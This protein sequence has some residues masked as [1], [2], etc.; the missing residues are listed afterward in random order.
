MGK[1]ICKHGRRRSGCKDCGGSGLCEHGRQRS[2]CKECCGGGPVTILDATEVEDCDWEDDPDDLS[3]PLRV[4]CGKRSQAL[5]YG[6]N[7]PT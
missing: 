5:A 4:R 2:K 1:A 3:G 7:I 6:K